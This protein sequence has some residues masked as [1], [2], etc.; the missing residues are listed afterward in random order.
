MF[1]RKRKV[2]SC[3][4]YYLKEKLCCAGIL[5]QIKSREWVRREI[6]ELVYTLIVLQ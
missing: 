2:A 1:S 6:S 5:I 3:E 4:A